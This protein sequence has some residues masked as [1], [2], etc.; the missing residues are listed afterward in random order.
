MKLKTILSVH[1][2]PDD[3]SSKGAGIIAKYKKQFGARTVLVT[4]TGGEEGDIVNK[5]LDRPDVR[6]NLGS[7]RASELARAIE[8]IGYDRAFTL[9]YRDSGMPDSEANS[10]P[11]AF[12][13]VDLD[14]SSMK[15]ATIIRMER[16]VVILTYPEIQD[17]YP[18]P[19]HIRVY[20]VTMRAVEL[21]ADTS[22]EIDDLEPFDVPKIYYHIWTKGRIQALHAK[23]AEVG[24]VSPFDDGW[25]ADAKQDYE[26]TTKIDISDF[27]SIKSEA[28]RA[29][30]TQIDPESPFWFGLTDEEQA[31]AYPT[32]DLYLAKA[33][34]GYEFSGHEDDLFAGLD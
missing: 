29:H 16:P 33:P 27:I 24:K 8:I 28:L 13:N 26:A 19:D 2:H 5:A 25:F 7:I 18:H 32:E 30:A 12:C 6:D 14:V 4:A 1:A 17:R 31:E 9:G 22:I 3:E 23:F 11:N 34:K 21:A 10:N 20:Q 15:L